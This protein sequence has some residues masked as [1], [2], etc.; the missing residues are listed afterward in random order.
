M[1]AA[2]FLRAIKVT[3]CAAGKYT[4]GTGSSG[5]LLQGEPQ[6][7]KQYKIVKILKDKTGASLIFVLA[8]MLCLLVVSVSVLA[9]ATSNAVHIKNQKIHNQLLLLDDSVHNNI[10]YSLQQD[11]M[12]WME[13]TEF[14]SYQLLMALYESHDEGNELADIELTPEISGMDDLNSVIT[15]SFT[16]QLVRIEP[17]IPEIPATNAEVDRDGTVLVP[18]SPGSPRV[19]K[20]ATVSARMRVTVVTEVDG[21]VMT[22]IASYEFMGGALT[23]DHITNGGRWILIKYEKADS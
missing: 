7:R 10:M 23:D 9:A 20:T 21:K 17:E 11:P 2:L 3:T 16:E 6:M 19:P 12:D 4:H 22:T 15:L 5:I 14:L 18:A 8:V 1:S 13:G